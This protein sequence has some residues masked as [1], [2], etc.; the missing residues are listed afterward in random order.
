MAERHWRLRSFRLPSSSS[1]TKDEDT[2]IKVGEKTV[3]CDGK[4]V[5]LQLV[6]A[7]N[8]LPAVPRS[9][10]MNI[11]MEHSNVPRG[12]KGNWE[13]KLRWWLMSFNNSSLALMYLAIFV[14]IN[15][16]FAG[17]WMIPEEKCCEDPDMSYDQLFDFSIQTSTTIGYG[18]YWPRGTFQNF[19]VVIIHIV[20]LILST[21]YAGLL[22]FR[23]VTPQ[24]N[25]V[26][27][28]VIT[29]S[30]V[31]GC[32]CLEIRVANVDG[33]KNKLV[34]AK[35][36][37]GVLSL[38]TYRNEEDGEERQF[39]A[40]ETL[41]LRTSIHHQFNGVWTLQHFIDEESPL[42]GIRLDGSFPSSCIM[43]FEL[44]VSCVQ[45]LTGGD[46]YLV[47][48]F[49]REDIMVG[50]R[51]QDQLTFDSKRDKVG[52]FDFAKMNSIKP[53]NVWY[54]ASEED[55]SLMAA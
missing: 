35:A 51:F 29:L 33:F 49:G 54:P 9:E 50:H 25:I 28:D 1:L 42:F 37:L 5:R 23:F 46:V 20:G 24:A 7:V 43:Y 3:V 38:N 26:T 6:K 45:H 10:R 48:R 11:T 18:G 32:P 14:I 39:G 41:K 34:N 52:I 12:V 40:S 19:L 44:C 16:I 4:E 53:A 15:A 17:L 21:V 27:S 8:D 2:D 36:S 30:N 13:S 47:N 22:L 31:L 55:S